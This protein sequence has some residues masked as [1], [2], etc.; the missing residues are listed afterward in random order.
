MPLSGAIERHAATDPARPAFRLEGRVLSYA[1]L[2]AAARR[3]YAAFA[4]LAP[5]GRSVIGARHRLVAIST[6]N[7]ALFPAAFLAA[8]T[9]NACAALIDPHL[10]EAARRRMID[11]LAPDIVVTAEGDGL[12]LENPRTGATIITAGG[13]TPTAPPLPEGG[14][15]DPFLI[16]FTS[17][18]TADPKPIIRD[19]RS[20]RISLATGAPFFGIG[21]S[22]STCAPGPLAHGLALYAMTETLLAGGLFHS[23]RHFDAAETRATIQTETIRR[24]VLVPTM[25]RRLCEGAPMAHVE[26]ITV[27]GAKLTAAD[28]ALCAKHFPKAA[29]REYYGAS[30]LGFIT[31]TT[32]GDPASSTAVGKAFPGVR[33]AIL[34][35]ADKAMATGETGAIFVESPLVATGYLGAGDGAGLARFGNLATVGDLG[36]LEADGTLHLLGRSGGM[37]LSGG[38]NIYPSEVEAALLG[39]AGVR[40]AHVFGVE[41]ADLGSELVAVIEPA[42][43]DLTAETLLAAMAGVLPRYKQPRRIWR[44]R[45]MPV[46][47]SGKVEAKT[48]RQW[49]VEASDA[50]ERFV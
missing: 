29:L 24:L 44:C 6:G 21:P 40:A 19:R 1:D 23:A 2:A 30:E 46:T 38:N 33:L 11:R 16:V 49:V 27:A 47:P 50:L 20:W 31:V 10:P 22:T 34:D 41:H 35:D 17:G 12:L 5:E 45:A 15:A 26:A 9:G 25:L 37:V 42:G 18:T 8:T 3:L 14:D 32:P 39:L 28:H 36:F 7:H 13:D 43:P 4:A 48:V